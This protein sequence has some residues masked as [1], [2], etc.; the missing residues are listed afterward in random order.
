[1]NS[2]DHQELQLRIQRLGERIREQE[3]FYSSINDFLH[4]IYQAKPA[5]ER[6]YLPCKV[7]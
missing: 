4:Q 6:Q 2:Q 7:A 1:M 5:T 3:N